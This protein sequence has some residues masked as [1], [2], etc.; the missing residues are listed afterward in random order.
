M[1]DIFGDAAEQQNA[2]DDIDNIMQECRFVVSLFFIWIAFL[3]R[4]SFFLSLSFI[5]SFCSASLL[6]DKPIVLKQTPRKN[7]LQTPFDLPLLRHGAE[8][9]QLPNHSRDRDQRGH[10]IGVPHL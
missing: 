7:F 1:I 4:R 3:L 6:H 10:K 5:A 9:I 2:G 8:K